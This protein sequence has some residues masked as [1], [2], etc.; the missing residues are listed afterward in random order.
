MAL[1]RQGLGLRCLIPLALRKFL[2]RRIRQFSSSNSINSHSTRSRGH[3]FLTH[4]RMPRARRSI[5]SPGQNS[6]NPLQL[7][8][9]QFGH[10]FPLRNPHIR[11]PYHNRHLGSTSRPMSLGVMALSGY[12]LQ[13]LRLLEWREIVATSKLKVRRSS[14]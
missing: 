7:T 10:L 12:R 14:R 3:R 4:H 1:C 11:H 13:H 9:N 6:A 2:Y 5:L 8:P